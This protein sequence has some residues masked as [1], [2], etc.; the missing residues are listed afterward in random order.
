MRASTTL[1]LLLL[2]AVATADVVRTIDKVESYVRIRS[3]PDASAE[4]ISRLHKTKP[5]PHVRTLDGWYEV[6]LED[7]VTGFVS[8]DWSELVSDED[9]AATD[10]AEADVAE[11]A[12]ASTADVADEVEPPAAPEPAQSPEP[13]PVP[14]VAQQE[15]AEA[16]PESPEQEPIEEVVP[17][18]EPVVEQVAPEPV[19]APEA[20]VVVA[21]EPSPV[22]PPAVEDVE[23]ETKRSAVPVAGTA[24]PAGPPGPPGPA[25]PQGPEGPQGPPGE[26]ILKGTEN[27]LVRFKE[28]TFGGRSQIYDDG[29]RIGIGTV[30]PEQKLEVNGSIQ[31]HDQTTSVAGVMITQMRGETGYI[32]HNQA[33]TMTIGAGSVDRIT[34]DKDGNIGFGVNRPRHPL[35]LASGAYVSAGGVWTNSSSRAL[36]ENIESLTLEEAL[37][38]LSSLEPVGFNYLSDA[39]EKH[40][41]FI[42]EDVPELVATTDRD[43]LSPMDIVAVLT[44]VV[45]EQQERIDSL[46]KQISEKD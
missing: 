28:P 5:R 21:E 15:P 39:E 31:I 12:M 24:G 7:G 41:G 42:A 43:S 20:D 13:E 10:Q 36:K 35:E 37:A 27:F 16:A 6:E 38:A 44:R 19:E 26:G 1:I 45:Q 32:L 34:I 46:E 4:A 33:S 25:G 18:A 17:V 30:E 11:A 2:S 9:P 23:R 29:N 40:L 14:A 3:A 8:S 22:E